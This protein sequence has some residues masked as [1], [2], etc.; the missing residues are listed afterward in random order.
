MIVGVGCD[1]VEHE[2]TTKLRWLNDPSIL[3]RLFSK[4]EI[5][6][7]PAQSQ[8][9]YY[10]GRFAVKEAILKCLNT[11]MQDGI[12][13]TQIEIIKTENGAVNAFLH[14]QVKGIADLKN[15]T[16][17]H[18]SITHSNQSSIAFVIAENRKSP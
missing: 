18:I 3:K 9:K 5:Q 13:L 14:G 12:S 11:G 2:T 10:S 16:N 7:C 4:S 15:I 1:I 8:N 6:K 17:W